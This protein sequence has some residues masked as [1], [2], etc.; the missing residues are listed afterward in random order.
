MT[1]ENIGF[2]LLSS[3]FRTHK[4]HAHMYLTNTPNRMLVPFG[5]LRPSQATCLKL[6]FGICSEAMLLMAQAKLCFSSRLGIT[7][8]W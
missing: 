8:T 6:I 1:I 4:S 3:Y 7:Q 2:Q 5:G